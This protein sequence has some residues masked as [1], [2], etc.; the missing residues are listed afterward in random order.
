MAI[1]AG[2]LLR[3]DVPFLLDWLNLF[4]QQISGQP[5][6][7]SAS[8]CIFLA[9]RSYRT[10]ASASRIFLKE[11]MA[12]SSME[13]SGS[14]VV[15]DCKARLGLII[16]RTMELFRWFA[17]QRT[18]S[19]AMPASTGMRSTRLTS[20]QKTGSGPSKANKM[21]ESSTSVR[22]NAVPQRVL[23]ALPCLHLGPGIA[24]AHGAVEYQAAGR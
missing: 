9:S 23:A 14:R 11:A 8:F 20:R 6:R 15:N 4:I 10:A 24:Q 13:A 22:R 19:S 1:H 12:T 17:V 2:L 3:G 16:Q 5:L 7:P 21:I 18:Y